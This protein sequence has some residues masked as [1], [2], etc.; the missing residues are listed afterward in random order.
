MSNNKKII[1]IVAI[2]F[3]ALVSYKFISS[4][5]QE[6]KEK[7]ILQEKYR[8]EQLSQKAL[9]NCIDEAKTEKKSILDSYEIY[10]ATSC[11]KLGNS[12]EWCRTKMY[13]E[14][15]QWEKEAVELCYRRYK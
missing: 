9:Q 4:G 1:G 7:A 2:V 12:K 5:I 11:T 13:S 3:V 6:N 10:D 15:V 8:L 14:G